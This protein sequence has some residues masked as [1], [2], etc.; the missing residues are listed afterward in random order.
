MKDLAMMTATQRLSAYFVREFGRLDVESKDLND[1]KA[2]E[3]RSIRIGEV[4]ELSDTLNVLFAALKDSP[5]WKLFS[6]YGEHRGDVKDTAWLQVAV[7]VGV[8]EKDGV[9]SGEINSE[10]ANQDQHSPPNTVLDSM[11]SPA[12]QRA[13]GILEEYKRTATRD[14]AQHLPENDLPFEILPGTMEGPASVGPGEN[15]DL[16]HSPEV[17]VSDANATRIAHI[18]ADEQTLKESHQGTDISINEYLTRRSSQVVPGLI[19]AE[20]LKLRPGYN[21]GGSNVD[22]KID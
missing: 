20:I 10:S 1:P 16:G 17:H 9:V 14:I 21:I 13:D 22:I 6:R 7:S 5:D 3:E 8:T 11:L 2:Q 18:K 4:N 19:D 12:Q 15:N